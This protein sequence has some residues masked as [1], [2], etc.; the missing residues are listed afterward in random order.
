MRKA[1]SLHILR[2]FLL[3]AILEGIPA[4]LFLFKI[5]S[6]E[7]NSTLLGY[8]PQRVSLGVMFISLLIL[9]AIVFLKSILDGPWF[10][11]VVYRMDNVLCQGNRFLVSVTTL[12]FVVFSGVLGMILFSTHFLQLFGPI[13]HIYVRSISLILWFTLV[14]SQALIILLWVYH[15]FWQRPRYFF[16]VETF[17]ILLLLIVI[18]A[19]LLH[20]T[21]LT[22]KDTVLAS[23]PYWWGSFRPQPFSIRDLLFLVSIALMIL[24]IRTITVSPQKV[25]RNL[26]FIILL[27]FIIQ[28]SFGYIEGGGFRSLK[29]TLTTSTQ[30][31]FAVEAAKGLNFIEMTRQYEERYGKGVFLTTKPPGALALYIFFEKIAGIYNPSGDLEQ[32]YQNLTTFASY[33]FPLLSLLVVVPLYLLSKGMNKADIAL[34]AP[35]IMILTPNFILMHLQLD[36][37]IY[38]LLF[39]VGILLILKSVSNQSHTIAFVSGIWMYLSVF[40]SFSLLPLIAMGLLIIVLSILIEKDTRHS[41]VNSMSLF[42][43]TCAGLIF[44]T[45]VFYLAFGYDPMIR[46]QNAMAHHRSGKL[47]QSGLNQISIA[48][49]QNNLEFL[50]WIGAPLFI[51]AI[52]RCV[53]SGLQIVR[54]KGTNFDILS[55]SFI[56]IFIALNLFG[57][58]RGEVGRIWVFLVPI[59]ALLAVDEFGLIFNRRFTSLSILGLSQLITTY[60]LFKSYSFF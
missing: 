35:L 53:R 44:S 26:G 19:T 60:F 16:K 22:L 30:D 50:F 21:I 34:I 1:K 13:Q 6:E 5:P 10:Q 7:A 11:R 9:I 28:V 14:S 45:V 17:Q 8:T 29:D 31:R 57:Q 41:L 33:A 39:V 36:Q 37:F 47:F 25:I 15:P 40:I 46:Y 3:L 27:G 18:G 55:V 48:I 58:T 12:S 38:P 59:F 2:G 32:R 42:I 54:G 49:T 51:L 23:F 24:T 43:S 52:S 20:W 56:I 4:L